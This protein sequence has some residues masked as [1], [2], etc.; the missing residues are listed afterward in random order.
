MQNTTQKQLE[1]AMECCRAK[2]TDIKLYQYPDLAE[3]ISGTM[4]CK[5][6]WWEFQKFITQKNNE[7]HEKKVFQDNERRL[8]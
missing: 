3:M 5:G 7:L 6:I 8:D 1:L 4:D 2:S